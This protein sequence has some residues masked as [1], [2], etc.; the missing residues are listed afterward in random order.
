LAL[1]ND[2]LRIVKEYKEWVFDCQGVKLMNKIQQYLQKRAS[3]LFFDRSYL[4]KKIKQRL[5]LYEC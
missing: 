3:V 5:L 1:L 4:K 2:T